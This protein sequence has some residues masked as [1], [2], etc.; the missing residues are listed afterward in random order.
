VKTSKRFTKYATQNTL[1]KIML[2]IKQEALALLLSVEWAQKK[3][4]V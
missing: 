2:G 1:E 3:I 4:S